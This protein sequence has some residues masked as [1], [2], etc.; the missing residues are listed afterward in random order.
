MANNN[1]IKNSNNLFATGRTISPTNTQKK[2]IK[3]LSANKEPVR[4]RQPQSEQNASIKTFDTQQ[5]H[6]VSFPKIHLTSFGNGNTVPQKNTNSDSGIFQQSSLV[7]GNKQNSYSETKN[8]HDTPK[9][10]QTRDNSLIGNEE[11]CFYDNIQVG[12]N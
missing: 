4:F 7:H 1:S 8:I 6:N 5:Q 10:T 2:I 11:D 12:N 9:S 3:K